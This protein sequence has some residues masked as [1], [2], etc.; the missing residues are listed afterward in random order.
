MAKKQTEMDN[1]PAT[2]VTWHEAR[3]Y[4]EWRGQRLPSEAEWEKAARGPNGNEF[5]WGNQWDTSKTETG[6]D[7]EYEEGIAP[8]GAYPQDKSFY[9]AYDMGGNVFEWVADWYGPY[10]GSNYQSDNFGQK[11]KVIRGGGGGIGHYAVSYLFR[12]AT[13]QFTDPEVMGEDVGF[14]CAKDL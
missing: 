8:V 2:G 7:S 5:P 1:Y 11:N 12:G 14:R 13:R 3:A 10:P 9:G 4:C 6:D